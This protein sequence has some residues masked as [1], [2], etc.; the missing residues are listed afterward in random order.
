VNVPPLD[1][2]NPLRFKLVA[3]TANAVVPKFNMLNQLLVVNVCIAVPL[4]VNVKLGEYSAEPP[5]V[6][7]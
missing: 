1:K 4:P 2:V 7:N 5:V 3:G 6:P